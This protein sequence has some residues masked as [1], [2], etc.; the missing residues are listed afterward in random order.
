M[1]QLT[2]LDSWKQLESLAISL[3]AKVKKDNVLSFDK[4]T[5]NY[6]RQYLTPSILQALFNLA[7]S[8]D[9]KNKIAGLFEGQFTSAD[10]SLHT[11]LRAQAGEIVRY[12]GEN[13][14]PKIVAVRQQMYELATDIREGRWQ[15][16]SGKSITDVVHLGIGGSLFGPV[17]CIEALED[18]I[19]AEQ[20]VHFVSEVAPHAFENVIKNLNPETTLFIIASKSFKTDEVICNLKKAMAWIKQ[21]KGFEKHFIAVTANLDE[22]KTYSIKHI[23]DMGKW[24]V[25]RFSTFSAINFITCIAIG[26][27][28]FDEFLEGASHLDQ[29]FLSSDFNNNLPV[30]LA[31]IG[32][33]NNNFRH[34]HYHLILPYG[35]NLEK[36]VNLT[37]QLEMESNGKSVGID[38]Q[39][40]DYATSPIVWGGSGDHAQHSYYQLIAQGTHQI[41]MDLISDES[42]NH[43]MTNKIFFSLKESINQSE[44][45]LAYPFNQIFLKHCIP[46]SVGELIALYEHK[47]FCQSVIWGINPFNQPG[48]DHCKRYLQKFSEKRK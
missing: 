45:P 16:Y 15:G 5:L 10:G 32:I 19:T 40:V 36:F 13:V 29:H 9:L 44:A 27:E 31:L 4:I 8:R 48:V 28:K 46:A 24:I 26:P 22:A 42:Y 37:Q 17:F 34:I 41:S 25:G 1:S 38:G 33:W 14:L 43:E 2:E 23:L 35:Q 11:A 39:P 3:E 18:F 20:H 12:Q 30:L 7:E 6:R 21:R 47:V